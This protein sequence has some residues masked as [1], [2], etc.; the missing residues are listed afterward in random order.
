MANDTV[1]T[2]T[3][4]D[5]ML[6][7]TPPTPKRWSQ[8]VL[9]VIAVCGVVCAAVGAYYIQQSPGLKVVVNAKR[10]SMA[11]NGQ[12]STTVY[13]V[14]RTGSGANLKFDAFLSQPGRT[15]PCCSSVAFAHYESIKR[16][17]TRPEVQT[18]FCN[19]ALS[20][21]NSTDKTID[22][23]ILVT[24]SMGNLIAGGAVANGVCELGDG[25]TWVSIAGPMQGSK[26]A[27]V[28]ER[29]CSAC[30]MD[31]ALFGYCP[32]TEAYLQMKAEDTVDASLKK[33]FKDAQTA[34][35]RANK[36]MCGTKS[37]GLASL[38]GTLLAVIGSLAFSEDTIHD[39]VVAFDS[40]SVGFTEFSS[41]AEVGGNY[42]A[43]IN[44]F[45]A[46]FRNGDGWWGADRKPVK[47]FEC[48]L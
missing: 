22:N 12:L 44:H 37:S 30:G 41:N 13:V 19:T 34:R 39:G 15:A 3:H 43:S 11:F 23:M 18:E 48:A 29:R 1:A 46:S 28:L 33:A 4:L 16:A 35:K 24:Y 31:G 6:L 14:P 32:A 20:I 38:G 47:W 17:W 5:D 8:R 42:K 7:P 40:C 27:N 21:G 26:A 9:G 2:P 10:A 25:V 36:L 45:D